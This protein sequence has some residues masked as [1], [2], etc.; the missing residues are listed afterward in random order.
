MDFKLKAFFLSLGFAFCTFALIAQPIAIK[1]N[2]PAIDT[3]KVYTIN[4]YNAAQLDAVDNPPTKYNQILNIGRLLPAQI[5]TQNSGQWN[6]TRNGRVWR[7]KIKANKAKGIALFGK[8]KYMPKGAVLNLYN[9]TGSQWVN[10]YT[11]QNFKNHPILSTETVMGE[12]AILEYFEPYGVD[13]TAKFTIEGIGYIYR[14]EKRGNGFQRKAFGQS[15][16]CQVNINCPEGDNWTHQKRA[17]VQMRVVRD[18]VIGTCTGVLVRT[19]DRK[20]KPY[21]LTAMHCALTPAEDTII[22]DTMFAYWQFK[23][24]YESPTCANPFN[25]SGFNK[26]IIIGAEVLS[27]S[28]DLG[29]ELGSDFILLELSTVVPSAYRAYYA[30]WNLDTVRQ[31]DSGA[32]IHHP[33]GDIR[34]ISTYKWPLSFNKPFLTSPDNTHWEVIWSA[35]GNGHGVTEPGS[36]G[37]P[38]FD[39]NGLIVGTLTGGLSKCSNTSGTDLF[40]RMDWH[41]IRNGTDSTRQLKYWLDPENTGITSFNG[42][43]DEIRSVITAQVL[44]LQLFPN[45]VKNML[46]FNSQFLNNTN[47]QIQIVDILGKTHINTITTVNSVNVTQL[48]AGIYFISIS[49]KNNYFAGKFIKQ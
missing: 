18:F 12:E 30:G 21:L 33:N 13:K 16:A 17:I 25:D 10:T 32:C 35:T 4:G 38:L 23:F 43:Y 34:K 31:Y 27:H 8:V 41:W 42:S 9:T 39:D 26:Q 20:Y 24:N 40:G 3:T 28:D 7:L 49:E 46:D 47:Y 36:S 14:Q 6:A 2:L 15:G 1:Q 45:P 44:P 37:A 29:G 19:T 11:A 5:T 22:N 48:P